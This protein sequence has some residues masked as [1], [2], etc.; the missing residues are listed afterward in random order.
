MNST[1]SGIYFLTA[2]FPNRIDSARN[3]KIR[4][5]STLNRK[6]SAAFDFRSNGRET[7]FYRVKVLLSEEEKKPLRS[8]KTNICRSESR[9][10]LPSV[11]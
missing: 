1:F 3:I 11:I 4:T 7:H 9:P 5:I 2:R 8:R 10:L 6:P